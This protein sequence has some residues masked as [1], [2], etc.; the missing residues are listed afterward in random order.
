MPLNPRDNDL[1]NPDDDDSDDYWFPSDFLDDDTSQ[2]DLELLFDIQR[3][4]GKSVQE[5]IEPFDDIVTSGRA[6]SVRG[7]RFSS[8]SEALLW[9]FR[10]GIFLYSSLVKFSDGT[11]GVAIGDSER[12]L[13]GEQEV[14]VDVPF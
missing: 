4:V 10:T 9:L 5:I 7:V 14:D 8:G 11:W 3:I 6:G 1:F 2:D 12:P 13:T